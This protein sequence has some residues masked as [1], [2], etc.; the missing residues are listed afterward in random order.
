TVPPESGQTAEGSRNVRFV[1]FASQYAASNLHPYSITSSARASSVGGTISPSAVVFTSGP[2]CGFR[3]VGDK[4][5]SSLRE[6]GWKAQ[7]RSGRH[8]APVA[9]RPLDTLRSC[10]HRRANALP[11]ITEVDL[12]SQPTRFPRKRRP[13]LATWSP[14]SPSA[15]FRP[16][17]SY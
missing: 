8:P 10:D 3:K 2:S 4:R 14:T 11:R 12:R 1:P 17:F 7:P 13:Y 6:I 5:R 15:R 9:S 16:A